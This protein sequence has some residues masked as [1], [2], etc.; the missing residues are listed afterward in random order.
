MIRGSCLCSAV[1]FE[2]LERPVLMNHC[3]CSMCRKVTGAAFGTF[4]H[5]KASAFQWLSGEDRVTR[6]RSS[7]GNER[8][9]C[10]VCG[11]NMP[12]IEAGGD[13]VIIPAGS[14]DDDPGIR[15]AVQIF[16]GSKAPW[17][18]LS[19]EPAAFEAFPPERFFEERGT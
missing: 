18:E 6:Y 7:E 15:P 9:F 2:L 8:A 16:T 4:V 11:S 14:L 19:A 12:V 17:H 13:A 1:R 10:S 3:H 5:G